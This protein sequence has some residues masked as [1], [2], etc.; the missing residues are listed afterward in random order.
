MN[1]VR[2]GAALVLTSAASLAFAQAATP[3]PSAAKKEL[4]AKVVQLQQ[5]AIEGLA[6]ALTE[7]SV[8]GLGQQASGAIAQRV[9]AEQREAV[10]KEVQG[11]FV[12]YGDEVMPLLRDR[13]QKL[14]PATLGAVLDER[15]SEEELK[16]V[17]A[18]LDAPIYKK[19]QQLAPELQKALTEKLVADSRAIVEPK[20]IALQATV[21]KHLGLS[22]N[23]EAVAPVKAAP[24]KPAASG[25]K[26]S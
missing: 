20:I 17:I 1:F 19:Y 4:I 10:A 21:A 25:A 2:I 12:K 26:K 8:Q 24:S 5:P 9:P 13:A 14:A 16:Q 11:D 15:L 6:R 3:A 18:M 23:A 22:P 7:Q